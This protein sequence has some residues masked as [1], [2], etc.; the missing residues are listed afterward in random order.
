MTDRNLSAL[1]PGNF[2][3]S[4]E[5]KRRQRA[6]RYMLLKPVK[7]LLD[8]FVN[9]AVNRLFLQLLQW[10]NSILNQGGDRAG[11]ESRT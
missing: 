6:L 2:R 9:G 1:L 5:S 4:L 10:K 3:C 7:D 11:T 8:A